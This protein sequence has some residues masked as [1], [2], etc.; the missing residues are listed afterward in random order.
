M[1]QKPEFGDV[2]LGLSLLIQRRYAQI[3]ADHCLT[4]AQAQ[5]MCTV[6]DQPHRMADL[7]ARLGMAKPAL[8]QLVDRTERRGLVQRETSAQD[9]RVI[10]LAATPAGKKIA[11]AMY[12]EVAARLPDIAGHL[13]AEDQQR[14]ADLTSAVTALHLPGLMSGEGCGC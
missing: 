10:T 12:A 5:L 3:C 1:T 2:L 14:L 13:C 11:D 8:S 9:R 4:P 7:A 6:R